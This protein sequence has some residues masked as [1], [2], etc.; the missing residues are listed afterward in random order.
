MKIIINCS[1]KSHSYR[2]EYT[3]MLNNKHFCVLQI[4]EHSS[5]CPTVKPDLKLNKEEGYVGAQCA[6]AAGV[7]TLFP[8]G[9]I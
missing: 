2:A 8:I 7:N 6:E 1:P 4:C 9:E 5:F 3:I